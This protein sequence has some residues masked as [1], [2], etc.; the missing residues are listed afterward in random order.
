[1]YRFTLAEDDETE[2]FLLHHTI[3][4]AFPRSSIASFTNAEDAFRHIVATGSDILITDHGM[5]TMSGTE[6]ISGLR[7]LGLT[8]PIIMVSGNPKAEQEARLAGATEF[9]PKSA[10]MSQIE[11]RITSLLE[12]R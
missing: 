5:G 12:G 7:Q 9:L 10:N 3:S 1:M 8:I 11:K 6:L 2:L 4:Q